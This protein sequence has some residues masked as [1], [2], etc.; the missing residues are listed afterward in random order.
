VVGVC[1]PVRQ[2]ILP[3]RGASAVPVFKYFYEAFDTALARAGL[4]DDDDDGVLQ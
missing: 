4:D 1:L 2:R 3:C